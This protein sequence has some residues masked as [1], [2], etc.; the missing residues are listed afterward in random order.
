[1]KSDRINHSAL[2]RAQV[3]RLNLTPAS[4]RGM[5]KPL[6]PIYEFVSHLSVSQSVSLCLLGEPK[7]LEQT[8]AASKALHAGLTVRAPDPAT[9]PGNSYSAIV[10]DE[11]MHLPVVEAML[12]VPPSP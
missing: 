6:L 5:Q 9:V 3:Q 7:V 2:S 1:M 11:H 12:F 4:A 10:L 8:V